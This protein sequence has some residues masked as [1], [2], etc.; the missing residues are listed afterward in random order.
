ME[1]MKTVTIQCPYCGALNDELIDCSIEPPE[2]FV[3]DCEVCCSPMLIR[4]LS[5]D[6]ATPVVEVHRE[7]E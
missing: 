5:V 2:E 3:E 4:I 7:N 1:C 6:G